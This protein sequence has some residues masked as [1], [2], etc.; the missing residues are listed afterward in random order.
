[1]GKD[2]K[3]NNLKS[4]NDIYYQRFKMLMKLIRIDNMLRNAKI[5]HIKTEGK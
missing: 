1:M 4:P 2:S 5:I 3:K